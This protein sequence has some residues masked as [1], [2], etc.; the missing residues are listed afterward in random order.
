MRSMLFLT[1]FP[2][3]KNTRKSDEDAVYYLPTSNGP[4]DG[5]LFESRLYQKGH[6][7]RQKVLFEKGTHV[8]KVLNF[9]HF[10]LINFI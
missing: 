7:P 4:S 1:L 10:L 2:V 5:F 3:R 6:W 8:G 9:P